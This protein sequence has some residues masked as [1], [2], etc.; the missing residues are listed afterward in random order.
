MRNL[1]KSGL[2]PTS[3][4]LRSDAQDAVELCGSE[5]A[6]IMHQLDQL[7]GAESGLG[8]ITTKRGQTRKEAYA[9]PAERLYIC[10]PTHARGQPQGFLFLQDGSSQIDSNN[11]MSTVVNQM[12]SGELWNNDYSFKDFLLL[13]YVGLESLLQGRSSNR[14]PS[15]LWVLDQAG[16][17]IFAPEVQSG[18][19]HKH[20]DLTPGHLPWSRPAKGSRS[21]RIRDNTTA[22]TRQM[23]PFRGLARAGGELQFPSWSERPL[24]Q[25]RSGYSLARAQLPPH[26]SLHPH[27]ATEQSKTQADRV[28]SALPSA[29]NVGQ[30]GMRMLQEYWQ[31]PLG[32]PRGVEF[33]PV[34]LAR[35]QRTM[36]V[37][38]TVIGIS[39]MMFFVLLFRW[40][41][42]YWRRCKATG[43][44]FQESR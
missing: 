38:W 5:N 4:E 15:V 10:H 18:V 20:G 22:E 27:R 39:S 8:V 3:A 34:Q 41:S 19:V 11:D 35:E 23:G 21:Q 26:Q 40:C 2:K 16:N 7:C 29:S 1:H 30:C 33:A 9:L 25:D 17:L 43:D 36:Y 44:E 12:L 37:I 42:R 31:G 24:M 28:L 32:L 6:T 13:H 14:K